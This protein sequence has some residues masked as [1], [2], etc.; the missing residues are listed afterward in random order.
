MPRIV[1]HDER[2]LHIAQVV[3]QLVYEQGIQAV[4]IREVAS[5]VGY[6]TTI[7]SHYFSS[8][9]EMLLFTHQVARRKAEQLIDDAIFQG[10]PLVETL[11]ELLPTTEERWR[12]WHTWFA[13]W[14][15]APSEPDV[16][17]EWREGTNNAHL[18]FLRL[19]QGAQ[20]AGQ[21]PATIDSAAA[22]TSIQI[23]VN[24]IASLVSQD[25]SGW[26]AERQKEMLQDLLRSVFPPG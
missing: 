22:A 25:R 4:T 12:D 5:R 26:P 7:V 11:E 20:A 9:L 1:D 10:R 18:L 17:R 2:R 8:K 14:G 15:M 16:T 24:G 13:F 3:D 23:F 21:F 19:V 6:S